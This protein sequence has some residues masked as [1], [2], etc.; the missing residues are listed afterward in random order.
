MTGKVE[1]YTTKLYPVIN[2]IN[3][4]ETEV[5]ALQTSG[6]CD[7]FYSMVLND[8]YRVMYRRAIWKSGFITIYF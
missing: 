4:M 5:I 7:P 2:D 3:Y 6:I 1:I 8:F